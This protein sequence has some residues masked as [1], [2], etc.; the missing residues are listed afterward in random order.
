MLG[1]I[2][3]PLTVSLGKPLFLVAAVAGAALLLHRPQPQPYRLVLDAPEELGCNYV[4]AFTDGDVV[5][6]HDPMQGELVYTRE[7]PWIDGC[8]WR[9]VERLSP[10]GDGRMAYS[11][12]EQAISCPAGHVPVRACPR[13]G[14]VTVEPMM[15]VDAA[16][17][18]PS[19]VVMHEIPDY[20]RALRRL[21]A[22]MANCPFAGEV[23]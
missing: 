7:N 17:A 10:L 16:E 1:I 3:H 14:I 2:R 23:D 18:T 12:T 11:Y 13:T 9:S 15:S 22:A 8:T 4:S 21:H 19:D 5:V 6:D 20:S